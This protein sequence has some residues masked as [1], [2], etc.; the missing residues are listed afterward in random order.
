M[1]VNDMVRLLTREELATLRS[2]CEMTVKKKPGAG[3]GEQ[4]SSER[5]VRAF[6]ID[7][8]LATNSI[9]TPAQAGAQRLVLG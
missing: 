9:V 6:R 5:E 1:K 7:W 4:G 3:S 2:E 8:L